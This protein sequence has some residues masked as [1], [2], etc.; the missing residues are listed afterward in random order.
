[1]CSPQSVPHPKRGNVVPIH[2]NVVSQS[3]SIYY[4]GEKT[5][6]FALHLHVAAYSERNNKGYGVRP[7]CKLSVVACCFP[8]D[9]IR[10][11]ARKT[12]RRVGWE[13][14]THTGAC[15]GHRG[16]SPYFALFTDTAKISSG[17]EW[18]GRGTRSIVPF[19]LCAESLTD[20]QTEGGTDDAIGNIEIKFDPI[21]P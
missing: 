20:N 11:A 12:E 19:F 3:R 16:K 15:T 18:S 6:H 7:R 9:K 10:T 8:R 5:L 1:M 4:S 2:K 17:L 14:P 13:G 21:Q